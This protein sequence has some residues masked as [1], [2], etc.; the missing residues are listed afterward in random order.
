MQSVTTVLKLLPLFAIAA[1]GLLSIG[2]ASRSPV[3]HLPLCLSG[4]T[5]AATLTLWALLGLESATIPADKVHDPSRTIPRATL[6]GGILTAAICML[7][8][9]AVLLLVPGATLARSDACNLN[10]LYT[11][12]SQESRSPALLSLN[13]SRNIIHTLDLELS[14]DI[15]KILD[16]PGGWTLANLGL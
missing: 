9:S 3:T 12:N 4:T 13:R 10:Y 8:C 5:A 1:V 6:V 14:A 2:E 15:S 11:P 16:L 7:A